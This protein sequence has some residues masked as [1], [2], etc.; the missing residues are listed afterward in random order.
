VSCRVGVRLA[1]TLA[2]TSAHKA[3]RVVEVQL[4][5]RVR[6]GRVSEARAQA[7]AYLVDGG[8]AL[9]HYA[10]FFELVAMAQKCRLRLTCS[11]A[12]FE[13]HAS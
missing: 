7:G 13:C 10:T 3:R 6:D 11:L 12:V 5:N 4:H 8:G 9:G 1:P 2:E